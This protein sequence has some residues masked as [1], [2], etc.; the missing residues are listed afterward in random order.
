MCILYISRYY[1]LLLRIVL[2][3]INK[4]SSILF[5]YHCQFTSVSLNAALSLLDDN[6]A[7]LTFRNDASL[8]CQTICKSVSSHSGHQGR[9]VLDNSHLLYPHLCIISH[10]HWSLH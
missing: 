9:G 1:Y 7:R 3:L 6:G 2:T 10:Y 4:L 5:Y 8:V